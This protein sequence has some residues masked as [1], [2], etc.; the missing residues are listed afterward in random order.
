MGGGCNKFE[1]YNSDKDDSSSEDESFN[2]SG[3]KPEEVEQVENVNNNSNVDTGKTVSDNKFLVTR[4][5]RKYTKPQIKLP[6]CKKQCLGVSEIL[7]Q[8][9]VVGKQKDDIRKDAESTPVLQDVKKAKEPRQTVK[10]LD[11]KLKE[12]TSF[13]EQLNEKIKNRNEEIK[14]LKM[15]ISK[16]REHTPN[17]K[18]VKDSDRSLPNPYDDILNGREINEGNLMEVSDDEKE[19]HELSLHPANDEFADEEFEEI[20][21][22]ANKRR[23]S[24]SVGHGKSKRRRSRSRSRSR[25][26]SRPCTPDAMKEYESDPNVQRLVKKMVAAQVEQEMKKRNLSQP[27]GNYRPILSPSEG[28]VYTPAVPRIN[29]HQVRL[30]GIPDFSNLNLEG[31]KQRQ[32]V[33]PEQVNNV[34]SQLRLGADKMGQSSG[35]SVGQLSQ[36][37]Q[38]EKDRRDLRTTQLHQAAQAREAAESAILEAE[39]FKAQIQPQSRGIQ[40]NN[41]QHCKQIEEVQNHMRYLDSEDDEFFHT[42]CHIDESLRE[43]IK[44]GQFVELCKLIIKKFSENTENRMQLVNRDGTSYFVPTTDRETKID[45]IEKWEQAFR[46]YTTIYCEANPSRAGEILQYVDIIHRAATIFNWDNVAKYDCL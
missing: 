21:M 36:Q 27:K 37:E 15:S 28:T 12:A 14:S 5:K 8:D 34:L 4:S 18:Q 29:N 11:K 42:T 7:D 40:F 2:E 26:R 9:L 46:V 41:I 31:E 39:R 10:S 33:S 35:E 24:P 38:I 3:K 20:G 17:E 13:L 30:S 44:K 19:E 43:K 6:N 16:D 32:N 45:G 22:V 25:R 1:R 23:T